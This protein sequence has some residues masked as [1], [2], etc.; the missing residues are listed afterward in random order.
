MQGI[1]IKG[2]SSN[3]TELLRITNSGDVGIGTSSP[4]YKLHVNGTA[5]ATGAAGAL[6][7]YRHK[8]NISDITF[9]AV[10]VI[11]QLRPVSFEWKEPQDIGMGGMAL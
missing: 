9:D 6:S 10:E 5:Y 1:T 8:T 3:S 11:N 7:D 2:T 4:S